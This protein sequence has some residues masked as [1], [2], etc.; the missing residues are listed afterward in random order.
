[1]GACSSPSD[2]V[3]G[4]AL[5]I[6]PGAVFVGESVQLTATSSDGSAMSGS[7]LVWTSSDTSVATVSPGGVLI[8]V[9]AG[10]VTIVATAGEA[11]GELEVLVVALLPRFASVTAGGVHTCALSVLGE[12]YCWGPNNWGQLGRETE[13]RCEMAETGPDNVTTARIVEAPCSTTPVAVS[14][15]HVFATLAAHNWYTC[16]LTEAAEAFCWGHNYFGQLGDGTQVPRSAPQPVAGG[17]RFRTL[18][19]GQAVTCGLTLSDELLCWGSGPHPDFRSSVPARVAA[20]HRFRLA[21]TSPGH[22][23]GVTLDSRTL[24]WG[25]NNNLQLGVDTV[26]T[27]CISFERVLPCTNVPQRVTDE[28]AFTT[29]VAN[30]GYACGLADA[31]RAHCWGQNDSGQLGD[32]GLDDRARPLPVVGERAF[33]SITAGRRF[34]CALDAEGAAFCWGR[35]EG[36]FGLGRNWGGLVTEPVA[37]APGLRFVSLAA[38]HHHACGVDVEGFVYCWGSNVWGEVGTGRKLE[39]VLTPVRVEGQ[40]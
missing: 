27:T 39:D 28:I 32:G 17:H 11:R 20:N 38:G 2:P 6:R 31:G 29:L 33:S 14:G 22:T 25:W 15:G 13:E 3:G 12:A 37:A 8:A 7:T 16:G 35:D 1:M 19:L 5:G 9:G 26:S 36:N 34:A 40:R 30:F 24:C 4:L 21:A 10:E 18:T 23:C